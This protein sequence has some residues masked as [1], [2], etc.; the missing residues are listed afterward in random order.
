MTIH[1]AAAQGYAQASDTY[2]QGRPDYPPALQ[3]WLHDRLG[4][5]AGTPALVPGAGA[6]KFTPT[7]RSG[8]G[9]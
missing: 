8:C 3:A 6:G 7:S 4:I 5:R 1:P 9:S 2:V